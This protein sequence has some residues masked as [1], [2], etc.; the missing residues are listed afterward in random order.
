VEAPAAKAAA[1][2]RTTPT[3]ASSVTTM[4]GKSSRGHANQGEGGDSCKK[5]LPGGFLHMDTL[6]LRRLVA[7]GGQTVFFDLTLI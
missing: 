5:G 7:P 4:L 1:T 6:H 3:T 2:V